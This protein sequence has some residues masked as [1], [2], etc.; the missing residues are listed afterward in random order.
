LSGGG[1][2]FAGGVSIKAADFASFKKEFLFAAL[3]HKLSPKPIALIPLSLEEC[4]EQTYRLVSSFGPFGMGWEAPRFLLEGLDPTTF[5]YA[6]GGKYLSTRLTPNVRLFSFSL[7]E[8]SFP[9]EGKTALEVVF[10]LNE[11]QGR[12]RVDL[13]AE[14]P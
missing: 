14:R 9:K 13:L 3:K 11:Y 7:N 4:T 2:E 6:A 5:T 1:H 12:L 10:S 8:D